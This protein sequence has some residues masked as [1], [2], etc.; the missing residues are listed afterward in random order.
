MKAERWQLAG[1]HFLPIV[2]EN[3]IHVKATYTTAITGKLSAL[4]SE[5]QETHECLWIFNE[6]DYGQFDLFKEKKSS[7]H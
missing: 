7:D 6:R 1:K 2:D 5:F 3:Q 4:H